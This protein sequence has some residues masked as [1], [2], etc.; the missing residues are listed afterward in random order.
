[1][2]KE[3]QSGQAAWEVGVVELAELP[4]E[5]GLQGMLVVVEVGTGD[6]RLAAPITAGEP[7]TELLQQAVADPMGEGPA[8]LPSALHCESSFARRLKAPARKLGVRVKARQ[9]LPELDAVRQRLQGGFRQ[10]PA[11]EVDTPAA[12]RA[13]LERLHSLAP[14]SR[15]DDGIDFA[16]HGAKPLDGWTALV[17]GSRGVQRGMLLLAHPGHRELL[18]VLQSGGTLPGELLVPCLTFDPVAEAPEAHVRWAQ[19]A[20]LVFDGDVAMAFALGRGLEPLSELHQR[21]CLAA[22]EAL[23]EACA[24]QGDAVLDG[25]TRTVVQTSVG[26]VVVATERYQSKVEEVDAPALVDAP[27]R[28]QLGGVE[29]GVPTLDVLLAADD[30]TR[31][32]ARLD[33]L[34]AL[35]CLAEPGQGVFVDGFAEGVYL[36][37]L[38]VVPTADSLV[39][40]VRA[41]R[42]LVRLLGGPTPAE[43]REVVAVW[44]VEITSDEADLRG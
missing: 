38:V 3:Q 22:A 27:H 21:L 28:L 34:I 41:R 16:F 35:S 6:V 1:M 12:W 9:E 7:L 44:S 11:F 5:E 10:A 36:G 40:M 25:P 4:R 42:C 43:A 18:P 13:P 26:P 14:W 31:I 20:G 23:A 8:G 2:G 24:K 30:A 15:I 32:A 17:S 33:G 39:P 29:G 19:E 37:T